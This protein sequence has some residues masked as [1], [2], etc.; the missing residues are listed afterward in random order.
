MQQ[1]NPY[2]NPTQITPSTQT[3]GKDDEYQ[4]KP[5]MQPFGFEQQRAESEQLR[6]GFTEWLGQQPTQQ[7]IYDKQAQQLGVP[8]MREQVQQTG[9]LMGDLM[10]QIKAR[11]EQVQQR[12]GQ[13]LITQAQLSAITSKEVGDLVKNYENIGALNTQQRQNLSMAE[14]SLDTRGKLAMTQLQINQTPWLQAYQDKN[15]MQARE[16]T[17]WTTAEQLELNRLLAN[18]QA[19]MTMDTNQMNRI[20]QLSM[21]ESQFENSLEYMEKGNEFALEFWG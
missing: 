17:G 18:Q 10:A 9:E 21:Q 11:P 14:Q 1:Q 12:A 5:T 13:S 4:V 2:Q 19:G 15:V 16:F 7:Q 6:K 20:H 8:Q 3:F